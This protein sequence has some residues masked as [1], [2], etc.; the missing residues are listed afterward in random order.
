MID[1]CDVTDRS[2]ESY[3]HI[4]IKTKRLGLKLHN[5]VLALR[6]HFEKNFGMLV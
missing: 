3:A 1:D 4:E 6:L 2:S 5:L